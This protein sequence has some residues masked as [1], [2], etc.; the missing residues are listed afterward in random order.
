MGRVAMRRG[1]A[2]EKGR[3]S[4]DRRMKRSLRSLESC[5]TCRRRLGGGGGAEIVHRML[6]DEMKKRVEERAMLE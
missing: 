6:D 5:L 1:M 3:R 4:L 2:R